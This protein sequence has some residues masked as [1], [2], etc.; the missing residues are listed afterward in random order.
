[1]K[2]GS[3]EEEIL[4]ILSHP[5]F[6][7]EIVAALECDSPAGLPA[8]AREEWRRAKFTEMVRRVAVDVRNHPRREL[9]YQ[10]IRDDAT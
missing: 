8:S 10:V 1:M 7:H 9:L 6:T 3:V 4:H 2:A 5:E